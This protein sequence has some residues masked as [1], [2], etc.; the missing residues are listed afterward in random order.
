MRASTVAVLV[1]VGLFTCTEFPDD[2][3][4]AS[5][6]D[7]DYRL[8]IDWPAAD[9]LA[10]FHPYELPYT[11]GADTFAAYRV[12]G[13]A[14]GAL[15]TTRLCAS[16]TVFTLYFIAPYSGPIGI[17]GVRPN[18]KEVSDTAR[19][20]V[21]N[22]LRIT[23]PDTVAI[24]ESVSATLA[25]VHATPAPAASVEWRLQGVPRDT[26]ATTESY[27]FVPD[28]GG[29]H[30][31]AAYL[32]DGDGN[33]MRIDSVAVLVPGH[34]PVLVD[35]CLNAPPALGDTL[36]CTVEM[37]DAD[38]GQML[39]E[40]TAQ[41]DTLVRRTV[42]YQ[43]QAVVHAHAPLALADTAVF[44]VR[45]RDAT[46]LWSNTVL[47]P[48][49]I[50][51][52]L[53][54]PRLP[55][56]D[57][58]IC[59]LGDT[60]WMEVTD[61]AWRPGVSYHWHIAGRGLDT[62]TDTSGIAVLCTNTVADTIIVSGLLLGHEGPAD[63]MLFRGSSFSYTMHEVSFPRQIAARD[64][65][66]WIVGVRDNLGTT[67]TDTAEILWELSPPAVWQGAE[68]R[69]D[70][71]RAYFSDSI[72]GLSIA[73]RAVVRGD[74]TNALSS[75]VVIRTYKPSCRFTQRRYEAVLG[76]AVRC[77]L[78]VHDVNTDGAVAAVY[79]RERGMPAVSLGTDTVFADSFLVPGEHVLQA[80]C[81]D[82]QG[83]VS[84]TDSVVVSVISAQ[85]FFTRP[86][87]DTTVFFNDSVVFTAEAN[88]GSDVA[89]IVRY[90][91]KRDSDSA[92][93]STDVG[94]YAY[95]FLSPG[96]DVL[97]VGCRNSLGD[98]AQYHMVY[99]I[100][101]DE[102]APLID[103]CTVDTNWAYIQ[104]VL[105]LRVLAHDTNE[106]IV[107][108]AIDTTGDTTAEIT[109]TLSPARAIDETVPISFGNPGAYTVTAWV[110]D[111]DGVRSASRVVGPLTIDP[112]APRV[113]GVE[114]TEPVYVYDRHTYT[115]TALDN[116]TIVTYLLSFDSLQFDT[117]AGGTF[118][119][120]FTDSGWQRIWAQVVDNDGVA[121]PVYADSVHV[122]L[123]APRLLSVSPD[124][125][126]VNDDTTFTFSV[127][128]ENG[129]V[130]SM[131]VDWGDGTPLDTLVLPGNPDDTTA[132][133]LY[134]IADDRGYDV[135]VTLIDDDRIRGYDTLPVRVLRG[136][137]TVVANDTIVHT[138][139]P[140]VNI[141]VH[142]AGRDTNGTVDDYSWD[143]GLGGS[144]TSTDTVPRVSNII[145]TRS[146]AVDIAVR[147]TDDDANI[148]TDTMNVYVNALP[149]KAGNHDPAHNTGV[150]SRTPTLSWSGFDEEDGADVQ[151]RLWLWRADL[152]FPA[153]PTRDWAG[154]STF[155]ADT[156]DANRGYSWRVDV[157]DSHG[158]VTLGDT[159]L[160]LVP[161]N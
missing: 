136:N 49:A 35:A 131:I 152:V 26:A 68:Q 36:S 65:A 132:N 37:D 127:E 82:N 156:L 63:T 57:S 66:Q 91:W 111:N 80:W 4:V 86:V 43:T 51:T 46:G 139:N 56:A 7:G 1:A 31:L 39:V 114:T 77:T 154:E 93:D 148:A 116:G 60:V 50:I 17:V 112:G 146:A 88:A 122:L 83:F 159:L 87:V 9:T 92:W 48:S 130:D 76:E 129:T 95:E 81:V 2:N 90:Y 55:A 28:A 115:I 124:T 12:V 69:H 29:S 94:S 78:S 34:R 8:E 71:L 128:D 62:L 6:Y 3:P 15:D 109:R 119:T 118:D 110:I 157:M 75:N 32:I 150:G 41:G 27:A 100:T 96:G 10:I 138:N 155:T 97:H 158:G 89:S 73:V 137:P 24:G 67:V 107:A 20:I 40:I 44:A 123:G 5:S 52:V 126:W 147:V 99:T 149:Q 113:T 140:S 101:V 61:A 54:E 142:A 42:P 14:T 64:T 53:P 23:A 84:D 145:V 144:W 133:H 58:L 141:T 79:R 33:R 117:V 85:P 120:A 59:Q 161:N 19:V 72:A 70:T 121:S 22:P 38:G 103:T 98:T 153:A 25:T 47:L 104:D 106:R 45:V 135:A 74:T 143:V 21:V 16:D 13:A 134:P 11:A 151:Y 102:G 108:L 125:V 105:Q 18:G 30:E 160:M